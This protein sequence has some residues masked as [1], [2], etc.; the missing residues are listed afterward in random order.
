MQGFLIILLNTR[1]T[2]F[3]IKSAN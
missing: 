3:V 2:L 1:M